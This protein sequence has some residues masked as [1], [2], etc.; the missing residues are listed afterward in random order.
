MQRWFT[1]NYPGGVFDKT[2]TPAI[3][4]FEVFIVIAAIV[5][6]F[7]FRKWVKNYPARFGVLAIGV[8][9]FEMFT[10][11]MWHNYHMGSWAYL[12]QDQSWILT[13]G[14]TTLIITVVTAIDHF[15]SKASP[16]NRFGL[17]LLILAPVVFAI[18]ILTVNIGIRTYSPEV[19]K[20]VCGVSVL[21]VPIEALYYVPVFMT[22]VIGFYK[23]WGL[24]LDGVPVVP[25]KNTPWFRT[26]LI[27]FAAVFLFEL[28]IEPMV[29][30]V[31]FPS[32]SYVYHDIT[33]IMTGLWIVGIWLVVNLID[34]RFIHWDLFHRFLLYL[35]AMAIVA[36]PV[37]AW[38]IA[39]GYRVY[40]PSAQANFTGVKLVGTSV[41][42]EVVF[43]IPMYMAL[44]IATI[45]VTE[46]AFSNKRLD[47]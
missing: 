19:L 38:F 7:L 17:Y 21:G 14:W 25:V 4:G 30:N 9:I 10:A 46:I 26:F 35:A 45:R 24:V 1:G 36:T 6:F 27:T 5:A 40:G 43:A 32:W 33:I 11:P 44:I 20:S 34:R 42:I 3:I 31:G 8:F 47:A 18:Q 29:D 37:E 22:L 16:F 23:Y 15:V 41:P 13:L 12:Y 28:M 2:P 39:H